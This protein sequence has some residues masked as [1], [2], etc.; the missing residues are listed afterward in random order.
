[1]TKEFEI[2]NSI[3][4]KWQSQYIDLHN[5]YTLDQFIIEIP[6]NKII[7]K[8]I[9]SKKWRGEN[10]PFMLTLIFENVCF[11]KMSETFYKEHPV[12]L[13]EIGFKAASDFDHDWL[14]YD[15]FSEEYHIFFRFRGDEFLRIY[16]EKITINILELERI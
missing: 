15:D 13:E 4:I 5:F 10:I 14:N 16:S 7:L 3:A 6:E 11:L 12:N 2:D 8:W 1:M 9:K